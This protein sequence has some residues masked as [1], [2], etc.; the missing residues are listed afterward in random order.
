MSIH[1]NP[2]QGRRIFFVN[3]SFAM[4]TVAV[5]ILRRQEYEIYVIDSY[6][7]IK[8]ILRANPDSLCYINIDK[9]MEFAQWINFINSCTN[10][11]D[12][13]SIL[14]GVMSEKATTIIKNAF[15]LK[16]IIPGGFVDCRFLKNDDIVEFFRKV[17]DLNGC[18]GRRAY[19][20][21]D[22]KDD[23]SAVM[24]LRGSSIMFKLLD[25][26]VVGA[27]CLCTRE[28]GQQFSPN[29]LLRDTTVFIGEKEFVTNSSVLSVKVGEQ[30]ATIVIMFQN[31]TDA[32]KALIH[33]Y[34]SGR[35]YEKIMS[36]SETA[37]PDDTDYSKEQSYSTAETAVAELL[38]DLPES[39]ELELTDLF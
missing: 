27:A 17:F 29:V 37:P 30:H 15:L 10:D 35:L 7:T 31:M 32:H 11:K 3:P 26:S 9:E 14:M 6:R 39:N 18:K 33:E 13:D 38:E 4:R 8:T 24:K 28:I 34:M 5:P 12:F 19:V 21:A 22:C 2:V 25:I 1:E 36:I 16:T 20:R 23:L